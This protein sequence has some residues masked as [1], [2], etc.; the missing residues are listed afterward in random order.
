VVVNI[1][2]VYSLFTIRHLLVFSM[3]HLHK[4]YST[5]WWKTG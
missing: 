4:N 3:F 2:F 5:A 1:D